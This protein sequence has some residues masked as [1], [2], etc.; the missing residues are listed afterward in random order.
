VPGALIPWIPHLG[1]MELH[2][3]PLL[4]A[5][6]G[7][8]GGAGEVPE[9]QRG[10]AAQISTMIVFDYVT[11][12]WDRWS[13]GNIGFEAQKRM[14]LFI[15]NDGAFYDAP[16]DGPLA[17]QKGR[18]NRVK[19]FSRGFVGRLRTLDPKALGAALGDESP[20]VPLLGEKALAGVNAR[21]EEALRTIDARIKKSGEEKTLEFD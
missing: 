11:G 17:A 14:L 4:S 20:G 2:A 12:N 10:L 5:W 7:W 18:L 9:D 16:P 15:D 3:E 19:R 8:L 13:G 21:R 1:L 6:Q